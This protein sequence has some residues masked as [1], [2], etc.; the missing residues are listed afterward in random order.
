MKK[1]TKFFFFGFGQVARYF[2]SELISSNQSFTFHSTNTKKTKYFYF[3]GKKFKSF[4]FKDNKYDKALIKEL[5]RSEYVLVSI[6][7][8]N[9]RDL[10]LK[11]FIKAILKNLFICQQQVSTGIIMGNG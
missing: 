9:K 7:P 3:R 1:K 11:K 2:I 8:K 4:K 5:K 6:P 10:V